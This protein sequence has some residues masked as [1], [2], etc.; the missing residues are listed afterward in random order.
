MAG[1]QTKAKKEWKCAETHEQRMNE[2]QQPT[3][4]M[5]KRS[6]ISRTRIEE[7]EKRTKKRKKRRR[8][9]IEPRD[10]RQIQPPNYS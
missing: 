9:E 7:R 2:G 5:L 1:Q 4:Q 6:R 10:R 3:Q 8:T